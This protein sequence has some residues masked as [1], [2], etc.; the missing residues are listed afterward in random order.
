MNLSVRGDSKLWL[1]TRLCIDGEGLGFP[2]IAGPSSGGLLGDDLLF[3]ED[4]LH[5]K[6]F[7]DV[8]T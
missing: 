3:Q 2:R 1:I 6:P 4:H 5:S 7:L 8:S